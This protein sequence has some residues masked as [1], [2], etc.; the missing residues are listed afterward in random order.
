MNFVEAI[1][2]I[3]IASVG[4]SMVINALALGRIKGEEGYTV[5]RYDR[6]VRFWLELGIGIVITFACIGFAVWKLVMP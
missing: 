2:A 4:G 5:E 6:P 3:G 1:T